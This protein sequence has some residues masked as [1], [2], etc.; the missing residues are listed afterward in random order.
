[1]WKERE[2][3]KEG[4]RME[5]RKITLYEPCPDDAH[6]SAGKTGNINNPEKCW[7]GVMCIVSNGEILELGL[8]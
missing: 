5:G 7:D 2:G 1:M 8:S 6:I 4:G 3:E